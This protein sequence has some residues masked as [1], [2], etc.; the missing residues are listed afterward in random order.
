M[1]C[2]ECL[3]KAYFTRLDFLQI[4]GQS[5]LYLQNIHYY[6]KI[7]IIFPGYSF[8]LNLLFLIVISPPLC[9]VALCRCSSPL[10]LKRPQLN[11]VLKLATWED[12]IEKDSELINRGGNAEGSR[13]GQATGMV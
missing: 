6:K 11:P 13:R 8:S 10:L 3:L 5:V 1:K 9:S 2:V 12:C 7:F 4:N